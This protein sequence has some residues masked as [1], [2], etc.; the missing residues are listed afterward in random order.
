MPVGAGVPVGVT[1]LVGVGDTGL[2]GVAF[3]VGVGDGVRVRVSRM[4]G[5]GVT[6]ARG[7]VGVGFG[8]V[9]CR[10]D[11]DPPPGSGAGVLTSR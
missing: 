6:V 1:E 3:A 5:L 11:V 10:P 8:E 9:D 4:V 7:L 2:V